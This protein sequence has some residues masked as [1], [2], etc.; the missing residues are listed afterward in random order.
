[1]LRP[2]TDVKIDGLMLFTLLLS[3]AIFHVLYVWLMIHRFRLGYLEDQ[4]ETH[5]LEIAIAERQ[6]EGQVLVGAG[7]RGAGQIR[8][9]QGSEL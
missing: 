4:V 1:M 5:G 3:F 7:N 2:D 9:G 6:A 8:A